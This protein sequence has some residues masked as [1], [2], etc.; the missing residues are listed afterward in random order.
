MENRIHSG[1][2]FTVEKRNNFEN[3]KTCKMRLLEPIFNTVRKTTAEQKTKTRKR[4]LRERSRFIK[5]AINCKPIIIFWL[6]EHFSHVQRTTLLLQSKALGNQSCYYDYLWHRFK[7][8][9][10]KVQATKASVVFAETPPNHQN[11]QQISLPLPHQNATN[12]LW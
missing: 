2:Y 5:E 7:S 6:S 3:V 10:G 12:K 8:F 11:P 4:R 1:N 9:I